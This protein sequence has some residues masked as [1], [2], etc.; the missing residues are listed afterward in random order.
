MANDR[1]A[2]R[3]HKFD[4]RDV[5]RMLAM[6]REG[7]TITYVANSFGTSRQVVG[8][9]LNK[10]SERNFTHRY[11]YMLRHKPMT[12]IDVDFLDKKVK[13]QNRTNDIFDRAFGKVEN[14]NWKQFEIFIND[15]VLPRTR[16]DLNKALEVIG[17][18]HYDP[19][20]IIE[21]TKGKMEG[22]KYWI[23]TKRIQ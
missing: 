3:K 21:K 8:R 4:N 20:L 1:N 14:P 12:I 13:I 9:Y 5:E 22:D 7:K 10:R 6:I 18:D 19:F 23:K 11:S 2:G 17:V 15:R 16:V